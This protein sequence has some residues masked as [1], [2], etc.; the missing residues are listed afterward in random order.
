[1]EQFIEDL[2][3]SLGELGLPAGRLHGD[4]RDGGVP[5]LHRPG[6]VHDHPR[7]RAGRRGHALDPAPDRD[8]R[9]PRSWSATRSGSAS[10]AGSGA[11]SSLRAR[12]PRPPHRGA[13]AEG[14]GLLRATRR[15]DDLHRPLARLRAAADA[16]HGRHVGD[17]LPPLPSLRRAER[18]ALRQ[19]PSACSGYIFWRSFEQVAATA[20]R[21]RDRVR[22][23]WSRSSIGGCSGVQAAAPPRAAARGWRRCFERP[24]AAAAAAA[25][26]GVAGRASGAWRCGRSGAT[27]LRAA[28]PLIA[29]P[30]RFLGAAAHAGRARHRAHDAARDRGGL[31][32]HV[33]VLHIDLLRPT[34][35]LTPGRRDRARHR[36]RHRD[37]A[38]LTT[39][40]KV[41]T[42]D[43]LLARGPAIVRGGDRACSSA[44]R[45]VADAV[46]LAVGLRD[47]ADRA[48]TIIEGGGRAPAAGRSA[49]RR[50]RL[51]AFPPATPPWPSPIWRSRSSPRARSAQ[52]HLARRADRRR[53]AA[54][55]RAIGLS[56]VYLRVHYL[57]DVGRRLGARRWPCSR[58]A[59]PSP[60]S[61]TICARIGRDAD[62]GRA[63]AA[64]EH[65][66]PMD[67]LTVTYMILGAAG[68]L[69]L[70]AL[71]GAD[72]R[73]GVDRLRAHL[74]AVRRRAS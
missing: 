73:A 13:P 15:Q 67:S 18:R 35:L 65:S 68:V 53:T 1:M 16:V 38:A 17:D 25:A 2:A 34:P 8:R 11:T 37:A 63:A 27:S 9:G 50:R 21:G 70:G 14:R 58:S 41:I 40:A 4:G 52:P 23:S 28:G 55:P 71:R 74:G 20:G 12:A 31:R 66:Q 7:R 48:S 5:R 24:G 51:R 62:R 64:R 61:S 33:F 42:R 26:R 72:P 3:Q 36:A 45:R 29:P 54:A 56:R 43:R 46:V 57:S 10:A 6:R 69:G 47:H 60:W 19:R 22:R 49:R 59:A 32:L 39:L 44:R 30:L